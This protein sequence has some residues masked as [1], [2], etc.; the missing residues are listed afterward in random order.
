M[1]RGCGGI[2]GLIEAADRVSGGGRV[3]G[4]SSTGVG[5]LAVVAGI[6]FAVISSIGFG[7]FIM[8]SVSYQNGYLFLECYDI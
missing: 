8:I 6:F 7:D 1:C 3:A 4:G 2:S 5:D